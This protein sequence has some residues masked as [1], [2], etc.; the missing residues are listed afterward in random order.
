MPWRLVREGS[1]IMTTESPFFSICIP[2]HDALPL[3]E[4]TLSS[5]SAQRF[6]D[7]EVIVVDDCSMDGTSEWLESQKIIPF[8]RFSVIRL[9]NNKGPFYARRVAFQNARG[10]YALSVDSDDELVG[11]WA[12]ER[13]HEVI[14]RAREQPDIVL[15]NA[16]VDLDTGKR[17]VDYAGEGFAPG[18]VGK[19]RI[20]EVFLKTHKLNNLCLKAIKRELLLPAHLERAEGL[21][22][23]EDRLEVAGVLAKANHFLLFDEPLYY[24]RQNDSSTTHGMFELD[25]FRQQSYVESTVA[26]F[27]PNNAA[28]RGQSKQFLMMCA[29]DMYRIA[30]GRSIQETAE[31]YRFIRN[32]EFFSKTY[33]SEGATGQRGDR[34]VLLR[35]LWSTCFTSAA[36]VAKGLNVIKDFASK[37]SFRS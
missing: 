11:E 34:A 7:W 35:L 4:K 17:W 22:M 37:I 24:Y 12:L 16:T 13:L 28:F 20:V 26:L 15:F 30:R 33:C 19:D 36:T 10:R 14:V 21:L 2:A 3:I 8:S 6:S 31:C 25:F 23:C 27:F 1:A 18:V 9:D 29:D 32:E 5:I